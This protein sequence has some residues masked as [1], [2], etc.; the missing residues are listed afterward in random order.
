MS[1]LVEEYT[2]LPVQGIIGREGIFHAQQAVAYGTKVVAGAT[3]GKG[4]ASVD[5][6]PVFSTVQEAKEKTGANLIRSR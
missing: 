1:V 5:G 2:R 4:G 6:I 3:P